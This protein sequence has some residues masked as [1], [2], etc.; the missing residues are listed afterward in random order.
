[1]KKTITDKNNGLDYTLVGDVYLPN[2]ISPKRI[3]RLVTGD[4][5]TLI[6]SSTTARSFTI[7]FWQ[8]AS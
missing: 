2:L 3:M 5:S 8:A 6:I 7:L 1:M 4:S